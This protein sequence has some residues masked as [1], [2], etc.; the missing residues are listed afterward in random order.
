MDYD[1]IVAGVGT[2]GTLTAIANAI[3]GDKTCG[4]EDR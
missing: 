3:I 1:V 2:A 4:D